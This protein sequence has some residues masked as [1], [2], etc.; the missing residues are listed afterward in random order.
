MD[1][2][3]QDEQNNYKREERLELKS[4]VVDD[5]KLRISLVNP[6]KRLFQYRCTFVGRN[7]QITRGPLLETA[8]TLLSV[9]E[10]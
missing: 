7:G 9:T 5:V 8:E 1:V 2:S 10:G 6:K 4:D 3:Y